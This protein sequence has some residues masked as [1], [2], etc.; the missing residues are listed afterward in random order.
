MAQRLFQEQILYFYVIRCLTDKTAKCLEINIK[1]NVQSQRIV[2]IFYFYYLTVQ[3]IYSQHFMGHYF[4]AASKQC[5][6]VGQLQK[7]AAWTSAARP[8]E[9]YVV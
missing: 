2:I 9:A 6:S 7:V 8:R 4:G 1:C 5:A 3:I